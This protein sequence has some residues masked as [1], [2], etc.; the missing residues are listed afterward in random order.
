MGV[1]L[2]ML[3]RQTGPAGQLRR[4]HEPTYVADL[5]DQDRAQGGANAGDLLH[6]G[7]PRLWASRPPMIPANTLISKSRSSITR[8]SDAIRAA[9][10]AGNSRRSNSSVP[11]T[12]NRSL[13]STG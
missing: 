6:R 2:M 9:Y 13:I 1:G 8:R 3:G 4:R 11:A 5:G 7:I 12:L 10:G